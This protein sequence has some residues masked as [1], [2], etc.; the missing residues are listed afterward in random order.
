[1]ASSRYNNPGG[2]TYRTVRVRTNGTRIPGD[3]RLYNKGDQVV[4]TQRQFDQMQPLDIEVLSRVGESPHDDHSYLDESGRNAIL[5][6]PILTSP[7]GSHFRLVVDNLGNLGTVFV[8]YDPDTTGRTS[9][10]GYLSESGNRL[11]SSTPFA[12]KGDPITPE[13][14]LTVTALHTDVEAVAGGTYRG[15]ILIGDTVVEQIVAQSDPITAAT[16]GLTNMVFPMNVNLLAGQTVVVMT[17]R[18]DAADDYVHPVDA[19]DGTR[20]GFTW[21]GIPA[22]DVGY[23][24]SRIAK[25]NPQVG[26]VIDRGK[27]YNAA[28]F[29]V[30][31]DWEQA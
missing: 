15:I 6:P 4:V 3:R 27:G 16:T 9:G 22:G 8:S 20:S 30:K 31:I 5:P 13:S 25:A 24:C 2:P 23:S 11:I 21:Q 17:G 10:T 1:M 14:P 29:N 19:Y 18:T 28:P 7:N 26:D 12:F